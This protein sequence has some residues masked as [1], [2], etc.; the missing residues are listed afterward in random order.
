MGIQ[1]EGLKIRTALTV[2]E[3]ILYSKI[4]DALGFDIIEYFKT[5]GIIDTTDRCYNEEDTRKMLQLYTDLAKKYD[6]KFINADNLIDS[7]YGCSAECC[8]TGCLRNYKIWGG[9]S[10]SKVFPEEHKY[11]TELGK[12]IVNFVRNRDK[13]TFNKQTL[14]ESMQNFNSARTGKKKNK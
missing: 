8:G 14:D 6:I 10:R 4:G 1:T 2:K 12:C 5:N 9:C 11:S 13:T 7:K 3:K